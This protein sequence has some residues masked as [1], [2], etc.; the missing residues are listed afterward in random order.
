VLLTELLTNKE[1]LIMT[2]NLDRYKEDLNRLIQKGDNLHTA[3]QSECFP[4][5]VEETIKKT[6]KNYKQILKA[7]PDFKEHYQVWY[8]EAKALIKQLL[9]DRFDDFVRLYEKPRTRKSI[10]YENYKIEDYMQDLTI[11]RGYVKEEVVGP[12][13][14]IPQFRQ[15]LSI[16]KAVKNRFESS[17]FDIRQLVKADLFDSEL[18]AATELLE[19]KFI[20]SAGALAGVVLETHLE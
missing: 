16:L 7:L 18:D 19:N 11:T 17:L 8:S 6:N 1:Q 15:Q 10:D 9:A 2:S 20:R 5:E 3:I 4:K 13:A 12:S 14:A